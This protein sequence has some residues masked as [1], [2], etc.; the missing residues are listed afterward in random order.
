MRRTFL[1]NE[2]AKD[3]NTPIIVNYDA[4]VL[5]KL[6]QYKDSVEAIRQN[7]VDMIY[8]YN[9]RFMDIFGPVLDTVMNTL[10]VE[11]LQEKDGNCIHPN[12]L[13]GA[14]FWNKQK[15]IEA[16]MENENF[17]SWGYE[18]NERLVRSQKLGYRVGRID[19]PCWHMH[20]A[21]STNSANT[22]H[23]AYFDNQQEFQK[24]SNMTPVQLKDYVK[25][26]G[27]VPK[28]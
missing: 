3:S 20:H 6:E 1:L 12:S 21:S 16:G 25:T 7:K 15:F 27:W 23:K 22:S 9:G 13:G 11:T 24:V 28:R 10:S 8:P 4:D 19:G 14:I 18:D 17:V 26:W 5:L 2:M